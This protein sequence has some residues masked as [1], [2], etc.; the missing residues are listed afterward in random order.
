MMQNLIYF[1]ISSPSILKYKP[2]EFVSKYNNFS[3]NILFSTIY[4]PPP[5]NFPTYLYFFSNHNTPPFN[6]TNF[7]NN[8]VEL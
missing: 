5:F 7:L 1:K 4:N 6:F 2:L 3:T 8:R